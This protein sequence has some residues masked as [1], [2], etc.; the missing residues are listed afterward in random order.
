M[1]EIT[2][3]LQTLAQGDA[4]AAEELVP[5]VYDELRH[6][7]A[8][9]L[10]RNRGPQTLQP[11]ALVH[12]AWLRLAGQ[13]DRHWN[14]RD[15]FF[16][17]AAQAMRHI[18]VD[19]SRQKASLKRGNRPE[20]LSLE[21]VELI[22]PPV[23]DRILIVHESLLSLEA[24]DPESARLITLKF[25]G[26]FTNPEIARMLGMSERTLERQWAYAKASLFDIIQRNRDNPESHG[27]AAPGGPAGSPADS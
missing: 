26:G 16:R 24:E 12:E 18:L 19:L 4:H 17:A 23:D 25:F 3:L 9:R 8:A 10:N 22:T 11:T 20:R 21:D 14:S 6:L 27:A 15:H 5:L 2:V 13:G 7:A 1:S